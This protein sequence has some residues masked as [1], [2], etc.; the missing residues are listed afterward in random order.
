[1]DNQKYTMSERL[2]IIDRS[3]YIVIVKNEKHL[4]NNDVYVPIFKNGKKVYIVSYDERQK[5]M[6]EHE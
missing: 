3:R 6:K 4:K 2:K 5:G 1:M